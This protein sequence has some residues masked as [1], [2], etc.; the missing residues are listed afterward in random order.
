MQIKYPAL[1]AQLI[2]FK[3]SLWGKVSYPDSCTVLDERINIPEV[4]A[5]A[6]DLTICDNRK[7]IIL[8]PS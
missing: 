1:T 6:G 2:N 4:P 5:L 7:T 8:Y 3:V